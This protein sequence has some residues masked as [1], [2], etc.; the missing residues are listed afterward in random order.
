MQKPDRILWLGLLAAAGGILCWGAPA[1]DEGPVVLKAARIVT[2]ARG[3]LEPGA[4]LIRNGRIAALGT[5]VP[6]PEGARVIDASKYA[7]YPGFIDAFTNLGASDKGMIERDDDEAT[8]PVTPQLRIIDGF[9]PSNEYIPLAR[10]AGVTTVL[11]APSI[12]NLLSGQSALVRLDGADV[13]TM[14]VKFPVAIH[15][16][17]GEAPKLRY[18]GKGQMP[19]T[20]MGEAA[21]LRQTLLDAQAYRDDLAAYEKK[22]RAY[23]QKRQD[24]KAGDEEKPVPP[25]ANP[26]SQ[27]LLPVLEARIPMI[28]SADRLD[29]ILTA[30]RIAGE[31]KLKII[32]NGGAE[33]Y[34]AKER[35]AALGVPVLLRPRA[36]YR[37]TIETEGAMPENAFLLQKAGVKFAFQTGSFTNLG[38]LVSQ[39][40][41]AV[42]AGLPYKEALK[43][44]TM[45]AAEIFGAEDVIGSL[46]PGKSA[47]IVV[48]DQDPITGPA[49]LKL[50]IIA[51]RVVEN[52]L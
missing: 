23:D 15:G 1:V 48:Y 47:D 10:R 2:V 25:A 39:A 13:E 18:G 12:G 40:R 46:E 19:M 6:I 43:A 27:S 42:V 37:L 26:V 7:A 30:L 50:V 31:F 24:G 35:L 17:L 52:L 9:D 44:L 21:L 49:R 22:A 38:D 32:L 29:D 41:M 16:S 28:I 14:I 33:A 3:V 34:K 45:N 4:I 8:S 51:G 36:A 5:D 11:A 20:R